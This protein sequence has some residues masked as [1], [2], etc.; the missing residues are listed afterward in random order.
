MEF[1]QLLPEPATVEID[2]LLSSLTLDSRAPE[3]RPYVAVN[4]VS[5][6]DGRASFGGARDRWA[7]TATERCSTGCAS[8]STR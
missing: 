4:F 3:D 5:T 2:A 8:T 1:R 6:V 7:M